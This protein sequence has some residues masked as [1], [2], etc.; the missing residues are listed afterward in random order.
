PADP[1]LPAVV[2]I[3]SAP[4]SIPLV[5][6]NLSRLAQ[7]DADLP[8]FVRE[9]RP[10]IRALTF[11][12]T[13]DW[14]HFPERDPH[15]PWPGPKPMPRAPFVGSFFI[16]IEQNLRY[17][18]DLREYLLDTPPLVWVLGFPL[19][20][21]DAYSWGFDVDK[22]LPT[23][24]HFGR[25]LRTL[26]NDALQF[27]LTGLVGQI[28][29]ELPPDSGF[30]ETIATDTKHIVAWVRENNPKDYVD[31]R[32]DK[33]KPPKADPDCGLGCKR[34]HNK[35][36]AGEGT[37][38]QETGSAPEAT[39][40]PAP[41]S[42]STTPT[43]YPIPADK[44][45]VGEFYWGYASGVVVTKVPGWGEFLVAELTQS[46]DH[47]DLS[48]FFPL[49]SQA[50][51][52]LG[53]RP[54]FGTFDA[55]FD[56][57]YVYAHFHRDG[58]PWPEAFA[59]VPFSEKGG[60]KARQFDPDGLPLCRAGLPMPLKSTFIDRTSLVEHECGRYAC[61]LFFPAPTDQ[62]CPAG[63]DHWA[64][65]G[66]VSCFPTSVGTRLRHQID[67]QSDIY[68]LVYKERTASERI[69]SQATAL[70]IETPK[71]RCGKAIANQNTLIYLIIDLRALQRVRAKK[72]ALAKQQE[73]N[74][75]ANG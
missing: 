47:G 62:P 44:A 36:R 33:T 17:M 39:A 24:R 51:K 5:R 67:R 16:K 31:D 42:P 45:R 68:K 53:F 50:E 46:F 7:P 55:G 11:L 35:K 37:A 38:S 54:T 32:Y 49:M 58:V 12:G 59:A 29:S 74:P 6:P 56:A 22:S 28:V 13:L 61:P 27:L 30:G 73:A 26:P 19:V 66:C 23:A 21:S 41:A 2:S 57:W 25:V 75:P 48:Y 15:R 18:S 69:N 60:H 63:D 4:P 40:A 43:T 9:S 14:D 1:P 52:T 10:A 70:G 34:R 20:P 72:A 65:G 3:A 8:L 71:L 64:K